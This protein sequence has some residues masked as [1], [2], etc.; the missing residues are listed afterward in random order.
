M[1]L[2]VHSTNTERDEA[3]HLSAYEFARQ[4]V[5]NMDAIGEPEG[6][7]VNCIR[8]KLNDYIAEE[9]L[10]DEI[11]RYG[12]ISVRINEI[13]TSAEVMYERSVARTQKEMAECGDLMR[14]VKKVVEGY[15]FSFSLG[16]DAVRD[17]TFKV[18]AKIRKAVPYPLVVC[19][20]IPLDQHRQ[21]S[22]PLNHV[23]GI[24]LGYL[25]QNRR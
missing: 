3:L 14:V 2:G 5:N 17:N 25:Y 6:R 10:A 9:A 4:I 7:N 16:R 13:P 19:A 20:S 24:I 18:P 1:G 22:R 8:F 21:F 12:S 15:G 23:D 11:S